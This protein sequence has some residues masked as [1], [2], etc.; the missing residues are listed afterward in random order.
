MLSSTSW[1]TLNTALLSA[2]LSGPACPVQWN[3]RSKARKRRHR[4]EGRP[5][6][7]VQV[8]SSLSVSHSVVCSSA[9]G[10]MSLFCSGRLLPV[11]NKLP[12][13]EKEMTEKR[14]ADS[15]GLFLASVSTSLWYAAA[16]SQN[17]WNAW[18]PKISQGM[19]TW[20]VVNNLWFIQFNTNSW[21][22]RLRCWC[23]LRALE[24]F[25]KQFQGCTAAGSRQQSEWD[26]EIWTHYD[27]QL[28]RKA[29]LLTEPISDSQALFDFCT[30][31][32]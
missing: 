22:L 32:S 26:S 16:I 1:S 4:P 15:Q 9:S 24:A 13:Q 19:T 31:D 14:L 7:S 29:L 18:I 5:H 17:A 2:I 3:I 28:H 27:A 6:S 10:N 20:W 8:S 25:T 11:A 12:I 21:R 30:I 23:H